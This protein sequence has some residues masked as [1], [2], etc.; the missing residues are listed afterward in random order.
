MAVQS[1]L[2]DSE[3]RFHN[4]DDHNAGKIVMGDTT[5][6]MQFYV[7]DTCYSFMRKSHLKGGAI[8]LP[9]K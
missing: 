8:R 2:K 5:Y 1:P 4:N 6:Q 3:S 9:R 7:L